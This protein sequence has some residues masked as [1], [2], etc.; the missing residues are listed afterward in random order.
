MV[1]AVEQSGGIEVALPDSEDDPA[2]D[3]QGSV[4]FLIPLPIAVQL[5]SPERLSR[6]GNPF[7]FWAAV[8]KAAI[9]KDNHALGREDKI[10]FAN[11]ADIPP[12][13]GDTMLAEKINEAQFRGHISTSSD[14]SHAF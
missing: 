8:P 2:L 13:A 1:E 14:A 3:A 5:W 12:P 4:H 6:F 9:N 11:Q 10:R 7:V